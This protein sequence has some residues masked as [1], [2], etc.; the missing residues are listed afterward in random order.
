MQVSTSAFYA[1]NKAPEDTDK[2][3]LQKQLEAKAIQLFDENKKIY[4]SRRLSEAFIKEDFQVGRYKAKQLMKTLGL[5]PRYPKRFKVTTAS[6]HN[7]AISPNHLNRQFD[8][9]APQQSLGD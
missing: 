4:G 8:V 6:D 2:K 7:D 5:K 1:W 3:V 9:T